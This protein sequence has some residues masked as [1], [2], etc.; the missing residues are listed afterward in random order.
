MLKKFLILVIMITSI[1]F[2]NEIEYKADITAQEAYQMQQNGAILIDV[3]TKQEYDF[4]R[5]KDAVLVESYMEI[6]GKRVFNKNFVTQIE[7]LVD[8]DLN[9][10]IILICRSGSRTKEAAAILAKNGFSNIYN[11]KNGF[12][13]DWVRANLPIQK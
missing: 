7:D 2:A 9:K 8:M 4:M 5:A 13:Y 3:R 1:L 6:N 12:V 10:E 11:V